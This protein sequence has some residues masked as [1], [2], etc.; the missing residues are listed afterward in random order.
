MTANP[1]RNLPSVTQVLDA[2]ARTPAADA[3]RPRLVEA[4]RAELA[5]LRRR[6]RAGELAHG[7]EVVLSRG[8]LVEI[9]GGFRIPEIMAVSGAVLREVGTTNI[10]R[11]GDYECVLGPATGLLLRVHRSNFRITGFTKSVSLEELA[12]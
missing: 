3:P 9:G 8:Q 6:P 7:K 11:I 12:A 2:A 5:D 4:V 10:T 1:Y